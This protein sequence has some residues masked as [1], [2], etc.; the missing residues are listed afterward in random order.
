MSD[1]LIELHN[2]PPRMAGDVMPGQGWAAAAKIDP[3]EA[4]RTAAQTLM[5]HGLN[6]LQVLGYR[7]TFAQQTPEG[8]DPVM[9][10]FGRAFIEAQQGGQQ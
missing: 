2:S 3:Y 9:R 7:S 6:R 4:G 1:A 10:G 8:F 5:K